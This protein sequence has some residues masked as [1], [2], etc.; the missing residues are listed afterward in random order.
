MKDNDHDLEKGFYRCDLEKYP[1]R[2]ERQTSF[3]KDID[4]FSHYG[5]DYDE[6]ENLFEKGFVQRN[7]T[8]DRL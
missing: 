3:S 8:Q 4:S 1:G 2:E 5:Y 7:N 6:G